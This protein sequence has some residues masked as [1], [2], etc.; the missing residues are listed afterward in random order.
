MFERIERLREVSGEFMKL[1]I[2]LENVQ[3]MF[4]YSHKYVGKF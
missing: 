2:T 1:P 3:Q 4:K